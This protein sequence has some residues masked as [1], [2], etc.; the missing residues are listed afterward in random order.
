[1]GEGRFEVVKVGDMRFGDVTE[2]TIASLL[3]SIKVVEVVLVVRVS[4]VVEVS[5]VVSLLLGSFTT[6]VGCSGAELETGLCSAVEE[7]SFLMG[8]F[9]GASPKSSI[10]L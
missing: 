8:V 2:R 4:L 10:D 6:T 3:S 1:M 9:G 7:S 5:M